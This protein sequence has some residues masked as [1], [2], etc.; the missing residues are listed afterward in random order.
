MWNGLKRAIVVYEPDYEDIWS[1]QYNCRLLEICPVRG[2]ICKSM[3]DGSTL[4][5]A[6]QNLLKLQHSSDDIDIIDFFIRANKYNEQDRLAL[7]LY[8]S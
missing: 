4:D 6:L 5:E 2:T 8:G 1:T 7:K 3:R